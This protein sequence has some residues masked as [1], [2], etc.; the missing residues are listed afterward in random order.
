MIKVVNTKDMDYQDWLEWR[1]KGIGGSDAG[2]VCGLNPYRSAIDVY[3]DKTS[4]TVEAKEPNETMRL[5]NDLEEYVAKR[6]EEATGKKVRKNNFLMAH[7]DYPFMQANI[8]REVV[9]ENAILECKTASPYSADKW[10]DGGIP[11]HYV[12]QCLHYMAVTGAEK[13]YLACLIFQRGVE[14]REIER[15]EET[16]NALIEME[17]KFW[18]E[19]VLKKQMPAPDGSKASGQALL[20]SYPYSNENIEANLSE[21]K[22]QLDRY[23]ELEQMLSAMKKEQDKIKQDIQQKM[24]TAEVGYCD[25]YKVT[26]KTS[27]PRVTIDTKKL[28][29]EQAD[30]FEQYKK[31]GNPTR[32]FTIKRFEEE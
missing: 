28:Q 13:C 30:I 11:P 1:H 4:K 5:G 31:V 3:V 2:A 15:D 32:R 18:N 29:K 9:G 23:E 24:K 26:W 16:I 8:D 25:N 6:W 17:S 14:F 7:D 20:D 27:K 19:N 22:T 12:I 21:F 10:A